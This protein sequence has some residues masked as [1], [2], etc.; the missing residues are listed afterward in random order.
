MIEI[1]IRR[2]SSA[3]IVI[4]DDIFGAPTVAG[5]MQMS[6]LNRAILIGSDLFA[7]GELIRT[8]FAC[9]PSSE[10]GRQTIS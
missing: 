8:R 9:V 10:H 3:D 2:A 7:A 1:I 6:E 5:Y 4:N